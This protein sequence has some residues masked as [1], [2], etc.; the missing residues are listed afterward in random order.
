MMPGG[1]MVRAALLNDVGLDISVT[2]ATLENENHG[3][4]ASIALPEAGQKR[5][6]A[7][8]TIFDLPTR[9]AGPEHDIKSQKNRESRRGG[10][11]R[12]G[13][14][15]NRDRPASLLSRHPSPHK[16]ADSGVASRVL[17][18]AVARLLPADRRSRR[19]AHGRPIPFGQ[20]RT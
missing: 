6:T 3:V 13:R 8:S 2:N 18:R 17:A 15:P 20:A 5:S 1:S 4:I 12:R 16:D 10:A 7:R 19:R 11:A 9:A 14:I